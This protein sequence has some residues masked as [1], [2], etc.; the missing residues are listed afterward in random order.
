[1]NESAYPLQWPTGRPRTPPSQRQSKAPFSIADWKE[2]TV[3]E[4]I[5]KRF[6][7]HRVTVVTALARLQ[8][9]LD[10]LGGEHPIVS[11]NLELRANGM[12]KGGQR[13]P[14]DP[15]ASVWFTLRKQRVVLSCDR[16]CEV[17]D[18]LAAIAAHIKNTRA[19]ERYGVG[20]LEQSFRGYAALEDYSAGLPWRRVLG[21]RDDAKP[22]LADVEMIYRRRAKEIH[23]D[24]LNGPTGHQQ[25]SQLNVAIEQAR[26]ELSA[27]AA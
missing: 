16:W 4:S 25:M 8:Q 18:N 22:T 5:T 13:N 11:S 12:P 21:V 17:A 27:G 23:P 26:R 14:L 2:I 7:N 1:M 24:S 3:G 19:L 6:F 20:T 9:Q 10:L 15:G